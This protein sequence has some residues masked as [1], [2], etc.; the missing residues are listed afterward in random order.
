MAG[1]HFRKLNEI[2]L[3]PV[4]AQAGKPVPWQ[5]FWVLGANRI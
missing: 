4:A 3:S 1:A 5:G 2:V